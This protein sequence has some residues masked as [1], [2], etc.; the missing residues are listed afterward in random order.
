MSRFKGQYTS[1][2][3][4]HRDMTDIYHGRLGEGV[5]KSNIHIFQPVLGIWW[6]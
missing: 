6:Q 1:V 4:E 5:I 3:N 2:I